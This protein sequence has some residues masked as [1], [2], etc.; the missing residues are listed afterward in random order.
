[1]N[2]SIILIMG[3][4]AVLVV[5]GCASTDD[6]DCKPNYVN[7][8]DSYYPDSPYTGEM[9][10]SAIRD[11][12]CKSACYEFAKVTSFKIDDSGCVCD[13]NNCNA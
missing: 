13:I 6:S 8:P 4:V 3:I 12:I 7:L 2:K 1:M 10:A 9:P 5:S 11:D